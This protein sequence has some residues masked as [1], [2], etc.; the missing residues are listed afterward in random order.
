MNIEFVNET[1][2]EFML[3]EKIHDRRLG[4]IEVYVTPISIEVTCIFMVNSS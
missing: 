4:E 1:F 3:K 2:H